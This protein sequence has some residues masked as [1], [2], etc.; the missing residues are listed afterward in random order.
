[1]ELIDYL[2]PH[3]FEE[4]SNGVENVEA[5]KQFETKIREMGGFKELAHLRVDSNHL[6]FLITEAAAT[7][8][9]LVIGFKELKDPFRFVVFGFQFRIK[10]KRCTPK[11]ALAVRV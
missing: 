9:S 2:I 5:L 4:D 8:T 3:P 10:I 11:V 6:E 7:L 1:M